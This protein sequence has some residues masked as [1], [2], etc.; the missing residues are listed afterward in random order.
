MLNV[1]TKIVDVQVAQMRNMFDREM[2]K[3]RRELDEARGI[4]DAKCNEVAGRVGELHGAIS[5]QFDDMSKQFE[6]VNASNPMVEIR[7]SFL[8]ALNKLEAEKAFHERLLQRLAAVRDDVD[9]ILPPKP[10]AGFSE[11]GAA[12]GSGERPVAREADADADDKKAKYKSLFF[13]EQDTMA[14]AEG[15]DAQASASSLISAVLKA[16]SCASIVVPDNLHPS[17][18]PVGPSAKPFSRGV[19]QVQMPG[20]APMNDPRSMT[21]IRGEIP[22]VFG[23]SPSV[24][25]GDAEEPAAKWESDASIAKTTE[26]VERMTVQA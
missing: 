22:E 11:G 25:A 20:V 23:S 10:A 4:Y 7:K 24:A 5:K 18:R 17:V 3:D 8:A 6:M 26:Q 21:I 12:S 19:S 9:G 2:E 1:L 14:A 16:A 15:Y 13:F